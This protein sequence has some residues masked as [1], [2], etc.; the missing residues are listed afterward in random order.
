MRS[1]GI[2]EH[3]QVGGVVLQVG[4]HGCNPISCCDAQAGNECG[5][6]SCAGSQAKWSELRIDPFQFPKHVYRGIRGAI[7]DDNELKAP[8]RASVR[9]TTLIAKRA[10][11]P[12]GFFH[13]VG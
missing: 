4:I 7:V 1:Q 6:L 5:G 10:K 13:K 11:S 12:H 9:G 3:D 8:E 2:P